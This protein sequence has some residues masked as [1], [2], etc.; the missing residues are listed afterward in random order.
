MLFVRYYTEVIVQV[1]IRLSIRKHFE[2]VTTLDRKAHSAQVN[3]SLELAVKVPSSAKLL[4]EMLG[5]PSTS[6]QVAS[7]A[8]CCLGAADGPAQGAPASS[9][10]S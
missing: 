6:L 8:Q 7:P 10:I 1:C 5:E 3:T 4:K 9:S 2:A